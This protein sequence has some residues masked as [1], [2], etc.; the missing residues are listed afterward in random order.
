M[1]PTTSRNWILSNKPTDC[2]I[3][4]GPSST[5]ELITK[6]IPQLEE[7][8]VLLKVQYLS[9]DPAQ[10]A[11][12]DPNIEPERLYTEPVELGDIMRSYASISLV[13]KSNSKDLPIGTLVSS[14][15]GWCDCAIAYADAVV[16][17]KSIDSLSP[18]HYSGIFGITG[19]TAYY[20]LVDIVSA[21][22]D[23]TVVI[24]GA[25]G[26]VGS[27]AVQ[28][29]KNVLGCKKVIGI[30]GSDAK[31]CWVEGLG[32]DVCLNYKS[33]LFKDELKRATEGFVDVFFDNTGGDILDLMLTRLAKDGRVAA[34][35]AIAD[36]NTSMPVGIKNWYHVISMRMR[37]Y[38][39]VVTDLTAV[40][41][42]EIME[43]L[44]QGYR[45]GRIRATEDGQTIVPTSFEDVPKTWMMLFEGQ[46]T[47]KLLTKLV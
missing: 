34:C 30:A 39:F 3:L 29:A 33:P 4:S 14:A 35:G 36:Y 10:R 12:I 19:V 1:T 20:G 9:N 46:N 41:W 6:P 37:I 13:V 21:G 25:A 38:G 43:A 45:D 22:P 17:L 44:V 28:I 16:P 40:R 2:P 15:T 5:F 11:W 26:A 7:E 47:G 23:D 24:S 32:A 42:G 31:C 8:Q 27:A 18:T